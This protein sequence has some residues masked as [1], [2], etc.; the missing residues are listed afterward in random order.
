MFAA[1]T[2][3]VEV[4]PPSGAAGAACRAAAARWPTKVGRAERVTTTPES[5][6]TAAWG[7][8]ALIARCGLAPLTPTTEDCLG[9]DGVDWVVRRLRDG[10][11]FTTYGTDPAL[12]VLIP[13]AYVPEPTL[14]P[15]FGAAARALPQNGRHC[16]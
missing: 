5:P 14:L 3:G 12:E 1:C 2:R 13:A 4:T 9:V 10:A 7:D 16:S 8:P 6:G 11:S 15:A